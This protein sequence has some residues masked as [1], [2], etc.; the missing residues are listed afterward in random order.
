MS[1]AIPRVRS[2]NLA[3]SIPT[4]YKRSPSYSVAETGL[5]RL[6]TVHDFGWG[7]AQCSA[8]SSENDDNDVGIA[9]ALSVVED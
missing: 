9:M 4:G 2:S 5:A 8:T 3:S 1:F 6:M 7:T